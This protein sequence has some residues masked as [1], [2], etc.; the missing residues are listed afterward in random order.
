MYC[1]GIAIS[2]KSI[3]IHA[4]ILCAPG[5]V[6]WMGHEHRHQLRASFI[7]VNRSTR[8]DWSN[9]GVIVKPPVRSRCSKGYLNLTRHNRFPRN[10]GSRIQDQKREHGRR[11]RRY[12]LLRQRNR[13]QTCCAARACFGKRTTR[14]HSFQ[15]CP[16][17]C[18]HLQYI[19][20]DANNPTLLSAYDRS[21]VSAKSIC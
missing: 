15:F 17:D 4:L 7:F 2:Y 10:V 3:T 18:F 1:T 13:A 14:P 16:F 12:R 11:R 6:E 20:F 9:S 21:S 19:K 8:N 5:W